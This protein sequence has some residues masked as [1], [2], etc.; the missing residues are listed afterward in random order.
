MSIVELSRLA[1]LASALH[2]PLPQVAGTW[3]PDPAVARELETLVEELTNGDPV[4]TRLGA[5]LRDALASPH[6]QTRGVIHGLLLAIY[7]HAAGPGGA[8]HALERDTRGMTARQYRALLEHAH[9]HL[10]APLTPAE[11]AAAST[12]TATHLSRALKR[13]TGETPKQWLLRRRVE[14]AKQMF[15]RNDCSLSE[16]A[17]AC[18]FSH[19]SHLTRVFVKLTGTTPRAWQ[20]ARRTPMQSRAERT[21]APSG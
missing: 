3:Q 5:L 19:Q 17:T 9:T 10:S 15:I 18:G 20:A 14:R 16:I 6:A 8:A 1:S 2:A 7:G 13:A 4:S 12:L 21:R 11:L